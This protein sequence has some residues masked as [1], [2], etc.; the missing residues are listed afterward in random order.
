MKQNKQDP[1]ADWIYAKEQE[2]ERPFF[3]LVVMVNKT[4]K[5]TLLYKKR[6]F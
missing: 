3:K 4:N 6:A 1:D 5:Y 2:S